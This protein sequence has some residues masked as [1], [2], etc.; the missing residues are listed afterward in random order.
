MCTLLCAAWLTP[1]L[2]A[3]MLKHPELMAGMSNP[4]FMSAVAEMQVNPTG[5][6]QKHKVRGCHC[7]RKLRVCLT[8]PLLPFP[9]RRITR[10]CKNFCGY[11]CRPWGIISLALEPH[12]E[13]PRQEPTLQRQ[14]GRQR[15]PLRIPL[16]RPPMH[17]LL[18]LALASSSASVLRRLLARYSH[19]AP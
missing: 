7:V 4:Q 13:N 16:A 11:S 19:Q 18:E 2:T 8:S 9:L 17:L 14:R 10:R 1:E 12:G 3:R 6:M 15:P 5:V